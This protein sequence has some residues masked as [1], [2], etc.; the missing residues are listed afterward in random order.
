MPTYQNG[1]DAGLGNTGPAWD[2]RPEF[3]FNAPG[4]SGQL[5]ASLP[6]IAGPGVNVLV[7]MT[8]D[9]MTEGSHVESVTAMLAGGTQEQVV[10][11]PLPQGSNEYLFKFTDVQGV[12]LAAPKLV[13]QFAAA[14]AGLPVTVSVDGVEL[15]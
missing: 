12:N 2:I 11:G 6:P 7:G 14:V 8:I 9:R 5:V 10:N 15:A 13:L 3:K 4:S 1:A